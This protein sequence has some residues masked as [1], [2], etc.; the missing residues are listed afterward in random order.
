M[1]LPATG[2]ISMSQIASHFG[3]SGSHSLSEYHA[4]AGKGVS[5]IPSSG[6]ISFSHFYGKSNQVTTSVWV[7]SGYNSTS[8]QY[9][10]NMYYG[11]TD[12]LSG[13][14]AWY[15]NSENRY[16]WL[17]IS[18]SQG[19]SGVSGYSSNVSGNPSIRYWGAYKLERST[20]RYTSR[21]GKYR[22]Y[23]I[24]VYRSVTTWVDT[25]SYQNQT[26]TAQITT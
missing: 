23:A 8:W 26:T 14:T 22:W 7:P 1:A 16:S 9:W 6:T 18:S 19:L 13:N 25:S 3:G 12:N 21:S 5:G 11:N 20:H 10:K 17:Q 15:Y 2:A 4:L 24:N